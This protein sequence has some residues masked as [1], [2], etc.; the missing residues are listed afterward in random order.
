MSSRRCFSRSSLD[1]RPDQ[2][3]E[4]DAQFVELGDVAISFG[5]QI[6]AVGNVLEELEVRGTRRADDVA[7][8]YKETAERVRDDGPAMVSFP[9]G[10]GQFLR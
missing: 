3:D 6:H 9:L 2:I 4:H 10:P 7:E 1:E 5:K 8:D